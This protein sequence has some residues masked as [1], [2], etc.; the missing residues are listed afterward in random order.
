M[1]DQRL[2][3]MAR[4][5]KSYMHEVGEGIPSDQII[6][7]ATVAYNMLRRGGFKR[8]TDQDGNPLTSPNSW[9][10]AYAIA[11]IACGFEDHPPS[12]P[13]RAELFG[14]VLSGQIVD[15]KPPRELK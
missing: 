12:T 5:A 4:E 11:L 14:V 7:R 2:V 10:D 1:V 3:R 13:E 15:F 9:D 8:A 6:M